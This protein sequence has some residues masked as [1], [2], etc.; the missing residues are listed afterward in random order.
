MAEDAGLGQD[1]ACVEPPAYVI[2][3]DLPPCERW[4]HVV[5]K[6]LPQLNRLA[7]YLSSTEQAEYGRCAGDVVRRVGS[8]VSQA[9]TDPELYAEM[10]GIAEL[11][12]GLGLT[13]DK[14]L[15]LNCGCDVLAR[16]TS[17]VVRS[18]NGGPPMHLRNMDGDAEAFWPLTVS[19][20]FQRG[21]HT[22]FSGFGWVGFVGLQTGMRVNGW[23]VSLNYRQVQGARAISK[24]LWGAISG[25]WPI[26]F[27][28]RL[29]L[30][31]TAIYEAAVQLFKTEPLMAPCYLTVCGVA[32]DEGCILE[33]SRPTVAH[34]QNLRDGSAAV[35]ITNIDAVRSLDKDFDFTMGSADMRWAEN[36]PLLMTAQLRRQ[37]AVANIK[38]WVEQVRQHGGDLKMDSGFRVLGTAPVCN[39]QTVY[40]C[41]MTPKTGASTRYVILHWKTHI[42]ALDGGKSL[43]TFKHTRE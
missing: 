18:P 35:V 31:G 33:R 9:Q 36:D 30:P 15:I 29:T 7:E 12:A 42:Q 5:R 26:A 19:L 32:A 25:A 40:S 16:C 39:D 21:G 14:L 20:S 13:Y 28:I 43:E 27:F 1:N 3:L 22:V 10:Q 4:A 34:E 11:T 6:S 24:N 2:D 17:A 23:S 8:L 37:V 38:S 41:I